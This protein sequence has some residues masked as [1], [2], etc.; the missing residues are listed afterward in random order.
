MRAMLLEA[1]RQPLRLVNL[2]VPKPHPQQVLIRIR[3][4]AVCRTDLHIVDGEL[5]HPKLPLIPGHQIVG[6]VEAVGERVEKFHVG[7]RVG[8]PWL[9][10]TCDRCRYC[11]SGRENLCD[12]A[13]FTGYNLDG[14]YAEYTVAD[15]RFCFAIPEG[16]PDLQAAPLLCGGL[17]GYRAYR[18]TGEAEK[19]GFY[20]FGSAAHMLIQL[21]RYQGR[22]VFAF[23]RSGDTQG[24]EFAHQLGAV[25]AGG[26]DEL[27][28]EPLDAAIIF[29]PIGKLV[30]AALRAVAKG[31]VVV[32][33]GIHMSD[34]PAFP[35]EILWEERVLR[36]V[37]NLTR[38]DGEEFLALAPKV[39]I[40]TEVNLFNLSEANEALDALRSGKI[41]GSAVLVVD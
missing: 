30:P 26:S 25:W 9:G 18:M 7:D 3:A 17:I 14:G 37:A 2:P 19:L 28:P 15:H 11:V 36:S 10:Y 5:T 22:Q 39:P 4:C 27:P 24:Q 29:A 23:T 40:Q 21:A 13:E 20:G 12:Y 41:E 1:P 38:Q 16:Y 8:V 6:I 32:C 35:Y 34:I 33:A 31:G